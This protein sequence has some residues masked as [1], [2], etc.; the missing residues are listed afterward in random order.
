MTNTQ[1]NQVHGHVHVHKGKVKQKNLYYAFVIIREGEKTK[2]LIAQQKQ[3][4]VEK[5]AETERKKAVIGEHLE[6]F[7]Q[8]KNICFMFTIVSGDLLFRC[9]IPKCKCLKA[10]NVP[11]ILMQNKYKFLSTH[12]V[13]ITV[14]A[15]D[16]KNADVNGHSPLGLF[17]TNANKDK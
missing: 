9:K 14:N 2:L 13:P 5:E 11:V 12:S 3:K 6:F 15:C 1:L 17:R 7:L 8:E 4:V 16:V 10:P